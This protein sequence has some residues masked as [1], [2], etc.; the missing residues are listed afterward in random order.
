MGWRRVQFL[1]KDMHVRVVAELMVPCA[2]EKVVNVRSTCAT[3]VSERARS[4]CMYVLVCA[5]IYVC[6]SACACGFEP[7]MSV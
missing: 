3:F 4:T 6:M 1:C 5:C 7:S 2:L